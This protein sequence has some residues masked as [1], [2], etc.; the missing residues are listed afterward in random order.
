MDYTTELSSEEV[1]GRT[2]AYFA[3]D[4]AFGGRYARVGNEVSCTIEV[5]RGC[6]AEAFDFLIFVLTLSLRGAKG[7]E[8]R[9][10]KL[11]AYP[12]EG[13]TMISVTADLPEHREAL[14]TWV[15]EDLG[16]RPVST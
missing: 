16:A 9:V 10:S 13:A 11:L 3:K 2:Q 6:L 8:Y 1:L 7:P 14:E 4:W 15:R 12:R 5:R